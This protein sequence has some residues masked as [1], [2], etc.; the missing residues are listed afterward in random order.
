LREDQS[1]EAFKER[2][3]VQGSNAEASFFSREHREIKR[4]IEDPDYDPYGRT[5]SVDPDSE[6]SRSIA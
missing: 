1:A 2:I 4:E 6:D 3:Q 5:R